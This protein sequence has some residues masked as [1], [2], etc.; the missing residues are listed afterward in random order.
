MLKKIV[1]LIVF[2][3]PFLSIAQK[4][5]FRIDIQVKG[6]ENKPV[7]F[8]Y[9]YG[10]KNVIVDSL[11]LGNSGKAFVAGDSTLAGGIYM[12]VLPQKAFVEFIIDRSNRFFSLST[13]TTNIIKHLKF[14]NSK[15]NEAFLEFQKHAYNNW[16]RN[17]W[18]QK[19]IRSNMNNTDSINKINNEIEAF[20]ETQNQ[21]RRKFIEQHQNSFLTTVIKALMEPTVPEP[22]VDKSL[23]PDVRKQADRQWKYLYYKNHYWDN[24]DFSD[25]RLLR[26]T[27]IENKIN[28]FFTRVVPNSVDSIIVESERLIEKSKAN[29]EVYR[30][31]LNKLL[32]NFEMSGKWSNDNIFVA[33]ANKYYLSGQAPW[34]DST[35]VQQLAFRVKMMIPTLLGKRIPTTVFT[36]MDTN[37]NFVIDTIPAKILLFYFWS[38]DCEHCKEYTP[39]LHDLYERYKDKGLKIV[40]ITATTNF[41]EWRQYVKDQNYTDWING[42][43]KGDYTQLLNLYDVYM[44]PRI[45]ILDKNKTIMQKDLE[46]KSI[47]KIIKRYLQ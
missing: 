10:K 21:Y 11:I 45:F 9:H 22:P 15:D 6:W 43:Y 8:E 24:I 20:N 33:L 38:S 36:L 12:F 34:A 13:D 29:P 46:V 16:A 35:F 17:D 30:F 42:Y 44:T 47:A 31:V 27:L 37:R 4:K 25:A 23:S 3:I 1:F 2:I 26:T 39:K 40:A 32:S 19:R 41:D 28:S 18:Y 5:G 7:Y 14:K